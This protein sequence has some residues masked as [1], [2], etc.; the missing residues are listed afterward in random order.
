MFFV[1]LP[2]DHQVRALLRKR[3]DAPCTHADVGL[4]E[5]EL[6]VAPEGFVLD[7]YGTEL[8]EGRVLFER[9][10]A[11]L[12]RF[13]NYPSSFTRVVRAP[14]EL[15][16][17]HLFATVATHFGFASVH[18]CRVL[19]VV[20][21]E[22]RFGFGFGTLA[23]HAESGEERFMVRIDG[24]R[25]RY[26]VLAFSRPDGVLGRLSAPVARRYQLR[27]QRETL[28]AMCAACA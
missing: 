10:C 18:P 23:G 22:S 1:S 20:H 16:K 13:G 14:G 12:A 15:A 11:V 6:E 5:R 17:G 27:F 28:A 19:Y 4:S 2:S 26:E 9:A 21:E 8:G 25:V 7:R 24:T 3:A